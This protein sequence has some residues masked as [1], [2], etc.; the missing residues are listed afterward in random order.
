MRGFTPANNSHT[1]SR[2]NLKLA[3]VWLQR[4]LT[5][6]R[7]CNAG[8]VVE[9]LLPTR[10]IDVGPPDGSRQPVLH[11]AASGER[12]AYVAL[13]H[14]WGSVHFITTTSATLA[15]RQA[16]I[17]LGDMPRSFRHAAYVARSWGVRYLWIDSLCILQDSKRDWEMESS[18][19]AD[20]YSGALFTIA[21]AESSDATQGCFRPRSTLGTSPVE[22][23]LK[24]NGLRARLHVRR[25]QG[26]VHGPA[27][28]V[29][30]TRGWTLQ[31]EMLSRRLLVF[32]KQQLMLHCLLDV[33]SESHPDG[34]VSAGLYEHKHLYT[35]FHRLP[36]G[37]QGSLELVKRGS[38]EQD[39]AVVTDTDTGEGPVNKGSDAAAECYKAWYSLVHDFRYRNL[40]KATDA[41]PALAGLATRVRDLTGDTYLAGLW[42]RDLQT[43]LL[44][45]VDHLGKGRRQKNYIA[46]SWSWASVDSSVNFPTLAEDLDTRYPTPFEVQD[47]RSTV[48]GTNPFGEVQ[49][50]ILRVRGV[51]KE[52]RIVKGKLPLGR[53]VFDVFVKDPEQ[54]RTMERWEQSYA[55]EDEST[56][57][58]D[59]DSSI[60][61]VNPSDPRGLGDYLPD[62]KRQWFERVWCLP[63]AYHKRGWGCL[64][65]LPTADGEQDQFRRVGR[66]DMEYDLDGFEKR[67]IS[68]V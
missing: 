1:G 50:G 66:L 30:Q 29:L 2:E 64:A 14:C 65:L 51:L 24:L 22:I 37:L 21:A 15:A 26:F 31:E 20:Y 57:D 12:A 32:G 48:A 6:H 62:A 4:C 34:W 17:P 45:T 7:E 44:W 11:A 19:M 52:V 47:V 55:D 8:Y 43:G 68:I 13:S 59:C 39:G 18:K 54:Q 16:G 36:R 28:S 46:P 58:W 41:L 33:A 9:A 49:S 27:E 56:S 3:A 61:C 63:I 53:N 25:L 5:T 23:S 42:N 67:C 38:A 10:V 60:D 35:T 40:T